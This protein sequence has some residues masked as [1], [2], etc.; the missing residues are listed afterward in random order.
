MQLHFRANTIIIPIYMYTSVY[1]LSK[2]SKSLNN[3]TVV[4][5]DL[6]IIAHAVRA[7]KTNDT[8]TS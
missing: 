5:V 1:L 7:P 3:N 4:V 6:Y 2:T 8:A